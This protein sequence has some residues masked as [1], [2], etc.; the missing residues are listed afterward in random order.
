LAHLLASRSQ[1][2]SRV[3]TRLVLRKNNGNA[4]AAAGNTATIVAGSPVP[5]VLISGLI[6]LVLFRRSRERRE[7]IEGE[8]VEGEGQEGVDGAEFESD[9]RLISEYG[10][11]DHKS[12]SHANE[13]D[14]SDMFTSGDGSSGDFE[15]QVSPITEFA[16]EGSDGV[17][18]GG[19]A[20]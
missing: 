9:A 10:F 3:R 16:D 14:V 17:N 2:K 1:Q 13:T 5:L 15:G 11:S 6:L 12:D 20:E 7:V 19:D 18:A 8:M 4:A